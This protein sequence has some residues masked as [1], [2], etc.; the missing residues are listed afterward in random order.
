M[1]TAENRPLADHTLADMLAE[2]VLLGVHPARVS[3]PGDGSLRIDDDDLVICDD[4]QD[5]GNPGWAYWYLAR[6]S[7][8]ECGPLDTLGDLRDALALTLGGAR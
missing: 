3:L 1:A 8:G 2:I 6:G 5:P 4:T 7:A